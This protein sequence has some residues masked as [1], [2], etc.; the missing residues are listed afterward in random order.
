[1]LLSTH[2]ILGGSEEVVIPYSN[3]KSILLDGQLDHVDIGNDSSVQIT[4]TLT[5]SAWVKTTSSGSTRIAVGKDGVSSGSRSY[6]LFMSSAGNSAGIGIFK[7]NS[8]KS[9][10]GTT[11][12]NTGSWFHVMGVNTGSDLKI[13]INGTLEGTNTGNGGTFDNGGDPLYIG[14]RGGSQSQRAFWDGNIDEVAIWN[15]DRSSDI[16]TIY[17]SGN[18][19]DLSTLTNPP[20]SWWR[21]GDLNDNSTTMYDYGSESNDGTLQNFNS[22]SLDTP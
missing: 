10:K 9:I 13:Y 15:T 19:S 2:G 8:F 14:R 4:N 3:S 20:L 11:A 6:F 18:P 12:V 22:Y 16:S 7:N 1:M 21:C 5:I 17:S